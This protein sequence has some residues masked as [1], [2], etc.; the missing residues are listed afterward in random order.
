MEILIKEKRTEIKK[1]ITLVEFKKQKNDE[2]F[3][4]EKTK[5]KKIVVAV[6]DFKKTDLK[7]C[8]RLVRKAVSL[9]KKNKIKEFL[10]ELDTAKFKKVKLKRFKLIELIVSNLLIAD[11]AYNKFKEKPK[12]GFDYVDK[13]YWVSKLTAKEKQALKDGQ[14]I[15][16]YVNFARDLAN[17]PGG[18]MTPNLL[19]GQARKV[20]KG[21]QVKLKVFGEK[22]LK[23]LKMQ[24]V[25]S[26]GQGSREESKLMLMEYNQGKKGE[27]PIVLVGKGVTFD[28]GGINLKPELGMN[29]MQ[30]DMSGGGSVIA[31]MA[32]IAELKL[33]KNVVGIVPAV[34]NMLGGSSYRPGD[35]IKSMSGKTIEVMNTDA[36]GRIIL[37]D[38]LTYAKRF[39][40][41]LVIDVATLT[42]AAMIALGTYAIGLFTKKK[43]YQRLFEDWGEK[44]LNSVWPLPLFEEFEEDIKGKFADLSNLSKQKSLGG[45]SSAAVFLYQFAKDY[46]W[47]HLDIAPRITAHK[48]EHLSEGSSGE[49]V[50]LLLEAVRNL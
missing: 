24:A 17:T 35:I 23:D 14:L 49:P 46:P 28:S 8:I 39:K 30:M 19:V 9:A 3:F 42:G 27:K 6:K 4:D 5:R 15:G 43:K 32:L 33:K 50:A 31:I 29:E 48:Q 40:P 21:T 38:A 16:K 45:A 44:S 26:V 11:Y 10:L 7:N 47:V 34:E 22:E 36:E 1:G 20:L 18:S 2:V 37:S 41:K 12:E 13:V 25:L